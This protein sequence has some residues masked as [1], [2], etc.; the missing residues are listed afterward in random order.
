MGNNK[1]SDDNKKNADEPIY[2]ERWKHFESKGGSDKDRMV[3]IVNWL[4]AFAVTIL[5]YITTKE[6]FDWEK[7]C[8]EP[9][10][11]SDAFIFSLAGIFI[12]GNAFYLVSA[13]AAYANQNWYIADKYAD[14]INNLK[15]DLDEKITYEI[16]T[17]YYKWIAK[18]S[19]RHKA[20]EGLA[21]IFLWYLNISLVFLILFFI[22]LLE[23]LIQSMNTPISFS[24]YNRLLGIIVLLILIGFAFHYFPNCELAKTRKQSV[25]ITAKDIIAIIGII[26]TYIVGWLLI[27]DTQ[28]TPLDSKLSLFLGLIFVYY[29]ISFCLKP[30]NRRRF[31]HKNISDAM[32]IGW[33]VAQFFTGVLACL[34]AL[35][36]FC[37]LH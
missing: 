17:P 22:V 36:P 18:L 21:R 9:E 4:L 1:N 33:L 30:E 26:Y 20:K 29:S 32:T 16:D 8:T 2:F 31:K 34:F 28:D 5:A 15:E 19:R 35:D 24:S 37:Y 11:L 27:Q 3:T 14:K 12:C 23:A 10:K 13:F 7:L 25:T 6:I